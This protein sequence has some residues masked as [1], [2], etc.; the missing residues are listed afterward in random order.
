[1]KKSNNKEP[2]VSVIIPAYNASK[3]IR[4]CV[5][6]IIGQTYENIEIIIIDDKSTDNTLEIA[7]EYQKKNP[8]VF[9]YQNEKNLGIG[10]NRTKGIG[11]ANGTYICWQDSDDVAFPKRIEL[12]VDY[13]EVHEKVGVV[14]GFLEFMSEDGKPLK[15][16]KYE[17]KDAAL[18]KSIFR[19]NPVA[20]PASMFRRSVYQEVGTYD[21]ELDVSEDIE[22][23]FRTGVHY[24]FANVQEKVIRYR[25]LDTSLTRSKLRKMELTVLRLRRRYATNSA[26][27]FTFLDGVY[28]L[29]Q[30]TSIILPIPVRL[31]L[32]QLI[33]GDK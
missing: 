26:Y 3:Y 22:M 23:L 20:Q 12:Q 10:A 7:E 11:I 8:K 6:S 13:L 27:K 19:Y 30:F 14:G 5:E 24:E 29:A 31:A 9:V 21:E 2:L 25:Q 17:E 33:R 18:R 15:T 4:E 16:R 32:F 28:N 1:M